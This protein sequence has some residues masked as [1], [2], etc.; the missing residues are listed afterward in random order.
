MSFFKSLFPQ[1]K[2]EFNPTEDIIL[3][4]NNQTIS[5]TINITKTIFYNKTLTSGI[6]QWSFKIDKTEERSNIMVGVSD[7]NI[8]VNKKDFLSHHQRGWGYYGW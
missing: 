4:N 3:S 6:H 5:S 7:E 2:E 1:K 8:E